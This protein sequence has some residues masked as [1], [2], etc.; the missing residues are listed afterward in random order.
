MYK[1]TVNNGPELAASVTPGGFILDGETIQVDMVRIQHETFH[2]ISG[3]KSYVAEILSFDPASRSFEIRVGKNKYNVVVADE[4]DALLK[5][6]GMDSRSAGKATDLKA[7]M[8]G[9]VVDVA[10]QVGDAVAKG[11]KLVVLEAMKMENI[12][13]APAE[14]V[15]KKIMVTKGRSVEKNEVLVIFE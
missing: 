15:I 6:L 3:T 9:L 4:Y 11:D 1:L 7:P 12:L 2:L 14:A 5:Q 13:K 10:V 8:P